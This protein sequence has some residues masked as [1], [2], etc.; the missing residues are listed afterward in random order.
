MTACRFKSAFAFTSHQAA[1][2]PPSGRFQFID[3]P[4][5]M[6]ICADGICAQLNSEPSGSRLPRK[7]RPNVDCTQL[8]SATLSRIALFRSNDQAVA[9]PCPVRMTLFT[10]KSTN[11][12]SQRASTSRFSC[13]VCP[14]QQGRHDRGPNLETGCTGCVRRVYVCGR[15]SAGSILSS[16]GRR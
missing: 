9:S 8:R 11:G 12:H 10:R 15:C 4:E 14:P 13:S 5:R 3:E 16:S 1:V 6:Q 7:R 2:R